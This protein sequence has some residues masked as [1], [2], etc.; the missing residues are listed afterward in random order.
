M[1]KWEYSFYYHTF[2]GHG[3]GFSKDI[4]A[5]LTSKDKESGLTE[6]EHA[7]KFGMEGWELIN[8][9]PLSVSG[10]TWGLLYVYKRPLT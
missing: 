7:N 2:V 4:D 9:T 10:S 1:Q 5:L 6:P 8:V 3:L